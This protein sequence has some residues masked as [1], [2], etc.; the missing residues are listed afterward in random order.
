MPCINYSQMD[1]HMHQASMQRVQNRHVE[2]HAKELT[3]TS[4]ASTDHCNFYNQLILVVLIQP[5]VFHV[6]KPESNAVVDGV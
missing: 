1:K 4:L 6:I 2:M 5:I 3:L